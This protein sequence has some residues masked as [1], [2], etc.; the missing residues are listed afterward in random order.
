VSGPPFPDHDATEISL[1]RK[2]IRPVFAATRQPATDM[3]ASVAGALVLWKRRTLH[4]TA[5]A[6]AIYIQPAK[7]DF[8][9]RSTVLLTKSLI[10]RK[11]SFGKRHELSNSITP[12]ASVSKLDKRRLRP[13]PRLSG[14]RQP[15]RGERHHIVLDDQPAL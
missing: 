6:Q 11:F 14:R 4:A 12:S 8:V 7:A 2:C 1:H 9:R 15:R 10:G 13:T 5:D 3:A